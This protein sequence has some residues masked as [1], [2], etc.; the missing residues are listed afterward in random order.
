MSDAV[1]AI[2]VS[3]VSIVILNGCAAGVVAMLHAWR[4]SM[5]R[6]SRV[7]VALAVTA[8]L[9]ASM[10]IPAII[11]DSLTDAEEPVIMAL[12]V[13]AIFVVALVTSLPGALIVARKLEA[14]GDEFRAFE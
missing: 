1:L 2:W 5:R 9:P 4:S 8:F 3:L 11:K 7:T 13:G 12:A 14:P 10:F 6:G